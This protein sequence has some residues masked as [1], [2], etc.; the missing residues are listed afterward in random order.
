MGFDPKEQAISKVISAFI[1]DR[2]ATKITPNTIEYYT[3][4][5]NRFAAFAGER[6]V[7]TIGDIDP[8]LIRRWLLALEESGHNPGGVHGFYRTLKTCLRWYEREYEP[9]NWR[10]PIA[11][12]K[13]P[14]VE[15]QP[16]QPV[17]V[18]TVTAMLDTCLPRGDKLADRDR[19]ILLC[20]LDT[21][22]RLTEFLSLNIQDVDPVTGAVRIQRGKG[23]KP[24]NVY[25]GERSRRALRA[26]L[27]HVDADSGPLWQKR[28][29]ERFKNTSLR[30]M[31][32]RRAKLAGVPEPS[33][34]DFR[35]AFALQSLRAGM[36]LLTLS[37]LLGHADL[38]MVRRYVAQT[39][40]DLQAA[41]TQY[42]PVDRAKLTH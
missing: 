17:T 19:A 14:K 15:I 25:L 28:T 10:N 6:G 32:V 3:K 8:D 37:R 24:R 5:L 23:G 36:D 31:F 41:H 40:D 18:E 33:P 13:A 21:G 2:R 35:R 16:L 42:S 22:A 11:K 34:H 26:W 4:R 38:Q 9:E 12:V 7:T 27:R 29:G 30:M 1:T 39:D 20:L